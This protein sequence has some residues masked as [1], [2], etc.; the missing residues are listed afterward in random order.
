[1]LTLTWSGRAAFRAR[2]EA[3]AHRYPDRVAAA[4]EAEAQV[5]ATE[6]KRRTPVETGNL[7]AS[8]HAQSAVREG[9]SIYVRIVCGGVAAPYAIY[10][11]EDLEAH[12]VVGQAKFLESTLMESAPYMLARVAARLR[13]GGFL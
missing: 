3:F 5:E 12:H 13:S 8:L 11:H 1:M 2:L 6:A 9:R 7:R 10:V 4:L